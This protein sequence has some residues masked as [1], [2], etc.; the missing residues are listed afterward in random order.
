M[1]NKTKLENNTLDIFDVID[2]FYLHKWIVITIIISFTFAGGIYYST[3]PKV[4]NAELNLISISDEEANNLI[5][6]DA[7]NKNLLEGSGQSNS[8]G[9]E[10]IDGDYL[11]TSFVKI[12]NSK[13]E[14]RE[15]IKKNSIALK[16]KGD[17]NSLDENEYSYD[18]SKNYSI[19]EYQENKFKLIY[20]TNNIEESKLILEDTI[21]R[22]NERIRKNFINKFKEFRDVAEFNTKKNISS[23]IIG[24]QISNALLYL[25]IISKNSAFN[26]NLFKEDSDD[27]SA[28]EETI[29]EINQFVKTSNTKRLE[30]I[31]NV[32]D[33]II[34]LP[35]LKEKVNLKVLAT[36]LICWNINLSHV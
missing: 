17:Y 11:L 31:D 8:I 35:I 16:N 2:Y 30:S 5:M 36:I 6:V 24:L 9:I 32:F 18:Q 15:S 1:N 29:E 12:F 23:D 28:I 14:L 7:M 25:D 26:E 33:K 3:S 19:N 22:I 4:F 34:N 10:K 27:V 20:S 13:N 21:F